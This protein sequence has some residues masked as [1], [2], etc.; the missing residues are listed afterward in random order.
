M[1]IELKKFGEILISR[2]AG[3]E[4]YLAMQAYIL[5]AR[6]RLARKLYDNGLVYERIRAYRAARVYYQKVVDEYTETEF[7]PQATF[8]VAECDY[9]LREYGKAR[10][11]FAN[12]AAVFPGHERSAKALERVP[13]AAFLDAEQA[14]LKGDEDASDKLNAFLSDFPNDKRVKKIYEYLQQ[15]PRQSADSSTTSHGQ[16]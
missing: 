3:R 15:Q 5:K 8:G 10:L 2:P 1:R 11:Q 16:S 6:T 14:F 13:E 12:F 4:A 7:G 9:R